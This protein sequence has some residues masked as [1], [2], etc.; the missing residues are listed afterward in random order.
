MGI[1]AVAILRIARL[2]EPR[3][4]YG[5]HPVTHRGDATLINT[6]VGFDRQIRGLQCFV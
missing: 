1:D 6:M 5:N 4:P 2:P 3:T